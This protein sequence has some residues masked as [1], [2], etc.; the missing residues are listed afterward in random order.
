MSVPQKPHTVQVYPVT[1]SADAMSK[2]LQSPALGS[3]VEVACFH[4]AGR[5]GEHFDARTGVALEKP[6]VLLCDLSD[7]SVFAYG[8]RV[9]DPDTGEQFVV[10]NMPAR[11][12]GWTDAAPLDHAQIEMDALQFPT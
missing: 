12:R 1:E 11:S 8:A 10:K 4:Y 5:V 2:V 3:A 6:E 9:I 7:Q